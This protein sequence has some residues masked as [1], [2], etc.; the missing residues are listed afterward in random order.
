MSNGLF[1]IMLII[2]PI[3]AVCIFVIA[4]SAFISPK[5]RA[6]ILKRNIDS[7]K[8]LLDAIRALNSEEI[9]LNFTGDMKPIIVKSK[10]NPDLTQ[11]ILPVRTY[12]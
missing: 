6:K 3:V 7:A 8:Y 10:N 12:N 1:N 11:L 9:E 2:I 4:F 5:F